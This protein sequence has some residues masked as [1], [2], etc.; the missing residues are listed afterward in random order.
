VE[1]RRSRSRV[2]IGDGDIGVGTTFRGVYDRMGPMEYT[3][4]EFDRPRFASVR[5]EAR[6]FR[7]FSTFTFTEEQGSTHVGCTMDPHPKG[8][9][10]L[11][12]PFMSGM[13]EQINRGMASLKETL[14][15]KPRTT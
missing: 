13:I 6:M 12:K 14:D 7:W 11:M 15:A 1:R 8:V 5:G 2:K 9:L 3:L 10:R 4:Q